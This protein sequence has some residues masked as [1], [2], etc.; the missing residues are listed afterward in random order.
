MVG[1]HRKRGVEIGKDNNEKS[2]NNIV[3]NTRVVHKG[4][5]DAGT[6]VGFWKEL[7]NRRR[8][9]HNSLSKDDRHNA[10]SIHFDRNVLALTA[11]NPVA[12]NALGHLKGNFAGA[13]NQ[14]YGQAH[15]H[16]Q[17]GDFDQE[18]NQATTASSRTKLKLSNQGVG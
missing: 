5:H 14:K 12:H 3:G 7:R 16:R 4:R 8:Q 10:S 6:Q 9:K 13:L 1:I 15:H 11:I 2:Q 17:H 18:R